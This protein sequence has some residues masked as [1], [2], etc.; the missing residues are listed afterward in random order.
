MSLTNVLLATVDALSWFIGLVL[1]AYIV[2]HFVNKYTD[3]K[4][5]YNIGYIIVMVVMLLTFKV[6]TSPIT[7]PVND[8]Y[9]KT[10]EVRLLKKGHEGVIEMPKLK[11]STPKRE[12]EDLS[13]T[14]LLDEVLKQEK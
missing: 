3:Y 2:K 5:K 9:D 7:R 4:L 8:I 1:I 10:N 6:I 12:Y 14:P 13:E 11:D